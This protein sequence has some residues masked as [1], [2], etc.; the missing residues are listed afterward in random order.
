MDQHWRYY[1]SLLN[2]ERIRAHKFLQWS[3]QKRFD[4]FSF[5]QTL[6][7]CYPCSVSL[8]SSSLCP[9]EWYMYFPLSILQ[10]E[11]QTLER[12]SSEDATWESAFTLQSVDASW[13]VKLS[14]CQPPVFEGFEGS[15]V[16]LETSGGGNP[17]RVRML[18]VKSWD[19]F[20][21]IQGF[22]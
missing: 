17:L 8:P 15:S 22:L 4:V 7:W 20:V 18:R 16:F 10:E 19:V 9:S 12:W 1:T 13:G 14:S 11:G 5:S 6:P 21:E 2:N 3:A